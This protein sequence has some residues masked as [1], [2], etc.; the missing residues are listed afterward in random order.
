MGEREKTRA[1][2][3]G[4][5]YAIVSPNVAMPPACGAKEREQVNAAL[6]PISRAN[7]NDSP[8]P[9]AATRGS[10]PFRR[11]GIVIL[12]AVMAGLVTA[13]A[14]HFL[15]SIGSITGDGGDSEGHGPGPGGVEATVTAEGVRFRML[16]SGILAAAIAFGV[17]CRI[18]EPFRS[19]RNF[20]K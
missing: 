8:I 11:V 9:P 14:V 3:A 13:G 1:R 18:F 17:A 6:V 12:I 19:G 2:R 16:L 4:R 7:M 15:H 10:S 20:S 5:Y